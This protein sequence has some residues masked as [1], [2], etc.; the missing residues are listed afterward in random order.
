Y[1]CVFV[2]TNAAVE[3]MG[4]M[5]I[6]RV[7]CFFSFTFE[8]VSYPCAV[9]HW[10]EKASN[11]PDEDTGMWIVKPSY[12]TDH[13]PLIGII[14]IDSIYWAAHLIPIYGTHPIP[15]NLKHYDSYDAFCT[16]YVNRFAD[17]HTFEITS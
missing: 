16:F 3:G 15:E 7:M 4:G 11:G 2:N 12:D 1:D 14:H 6:G 13:S 5:D 17:H 10:F 8:A 9:V